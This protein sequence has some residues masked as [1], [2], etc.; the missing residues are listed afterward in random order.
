MYFEELLVIRTYVDFN[1]VS[2]KQI[3]LF[4]TCM[5]WH[6]CTDFGRETSMVCCVD[7]YAAKWLCRWSHRPSK[8]HSVYGGIICAG[9]NGKMLQIWNADHD[10][11]AVCMSS[12]ET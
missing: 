11:Y 8:L 7:T 4:A 5:A 3:A 9:I 2:Y 12:I 10:T 6:E 1:S